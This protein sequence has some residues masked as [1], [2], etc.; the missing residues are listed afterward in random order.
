MFTSSNPRQQLC[1]GVNILLSKCVNICSQSLTRQKAACNRMQFDWI[2]MRLSCPLT[3]PD[4]S[5]TLDPWQEIK[6]HGWHRKGR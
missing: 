6:I 1:T 4:K 3:G 5:L 2:Q